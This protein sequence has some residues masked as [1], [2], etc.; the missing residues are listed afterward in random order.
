V[1]DEGLATA[2]TDAGAAVA[3]VATT[4]RVDDFDHKVLVPGRG[5]VPVNVA[6]T[7]R[8]TWFCSAKFFGDPHPKRTGYRR[9]AHTFQR[10]LQ[11]LLP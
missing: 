2:Y 8:W 3:D 6:L 7:C 4:F 10:E 1:F 5:W 9:I 11:P